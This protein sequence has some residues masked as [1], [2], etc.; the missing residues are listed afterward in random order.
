MGGFFFVIYDIKDLTPTYLDLVR[1][2]S[3]ILL[4]VIPPKAQI[5]I[6]QFNVIKL[7]LEI[8]SILFGEY[9]LL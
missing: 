8:P 5:F 9:F 3:F 4:E 2:I 1:L 7:N 6:F